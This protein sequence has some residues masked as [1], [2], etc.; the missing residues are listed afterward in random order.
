MTESE[1]LAIKERDAIVSLKIK[2]P[3]YS[4]TK[5]F[6]DE[7]ARETLEALRKAANDMLTLEDGEYV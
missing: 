4:E 7:R 6:L 2:V 3:H 5:A 1:M